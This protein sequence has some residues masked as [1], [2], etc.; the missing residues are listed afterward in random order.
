MI[1]QPTRSTLLPYTTL[2]RSSKAELPM[3]RERFTRKPPERPT[4]NSR[5]SSAFSGRDTKASASRCR[6]VRSEEHTSELQ[7][8]AYLVCRLRFEKKK[9]RRPVLPGRGSGG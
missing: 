6:I 7:S 8:L 1:R 9:S 3:E 5:T 2:F 4:E